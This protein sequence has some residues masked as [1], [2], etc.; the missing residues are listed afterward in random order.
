MREEN[1]NPRAQA[2]TRYNLPPIDRLLKPRN[3]RTS[4]QVGD[5][6]ETIIGEEMPPSTGKTLQ[7]RLINILLL[8]FKYYRLYLPSK[9]KRIQC[10]FNFY[11]ILIAI[12]FYYLKFCVRSYGKK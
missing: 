8:F 1:I 9:V 10:L 12:L 5:F 3:W 4:I 7:T 2:G 11:V 6:P